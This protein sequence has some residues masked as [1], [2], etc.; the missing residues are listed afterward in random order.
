MKLYVTKAEDRDSM[1]VI[2]ARNGYTVR[3]G[4]EKPT[5]GGKKSI[6]FVEVVDDGKRSATSGSGN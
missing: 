5:G 6:S 3:Q 1:I 4:T 2:L